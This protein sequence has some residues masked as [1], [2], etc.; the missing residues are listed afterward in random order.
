MCRLFRLD[1]LS[2]N[3]PFTRFPVSRFQL[4]RG[5]VIAEIETSRR[6]RVGTG[7]WVSPFPLGMG[8]EGGH[9]SYTIF[10]NFRF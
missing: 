7:S 10:F 5:A 2:T 6:V 1:P 3:N 4:R 8:L 9:N